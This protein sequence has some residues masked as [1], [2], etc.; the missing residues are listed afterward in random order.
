MRGGERE[1]R[2]RRDGEIG[3]KGKRADNFD[4]V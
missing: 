3:R 4:R 1:K 2:R